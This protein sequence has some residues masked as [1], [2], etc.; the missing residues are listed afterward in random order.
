MKRGGGNSFPVRPTLDA[1][2]YP[3]KTCHRAILGRNLHWFA[4][5]YG[6]YKVSISLQTIS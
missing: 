3:Q 2:R 4:A 1:F 5:I 6:R